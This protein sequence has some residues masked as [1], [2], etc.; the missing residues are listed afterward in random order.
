MEL[1][2]NYYILFNNYKSFIRNY[3]FLN[4]LTDFFRMILCI[5]Y[6]NLKV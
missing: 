2:P 1:L 4:T 5:F 6:S 3:N